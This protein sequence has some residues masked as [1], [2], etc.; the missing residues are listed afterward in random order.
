VRMT[1]LLVAASAL[2]AGSGCVPVKRSPEA[3]YLVLRA[4]AEPAAAPGPNQESLLGLQPVLVPESLARPQ[5]VTAAAPGELRVDTVLRW[6]E[7]LDEGATRTTAENLGALL[8]GWRVLRSPWPVSAPLRARLQVDIRTF[9]PRAD[10]SVRLEGGF[11]ILQPSE[12][13]ALVRRTFSL[14]RPQPAGNAAA[15]AMSALLGDLA[16]QVASAV[17][18]LPAP[19]PAPGSGG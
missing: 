3:R 18:A 10:G 13:R 11:V 7:P 2:A 6:A 17:E 1:A 19:T 12:E 14:S 15:E 8:P 4:V 9:G 16:R 5:L